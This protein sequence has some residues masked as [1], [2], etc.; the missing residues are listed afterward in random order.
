MRGPKAIVSK[1]K[2]ELESIAAGL[3]DRV[4]LGVS[5]PAAQHR[6]LIGRGG[7]T[8]NALQDKHSVQVQFPGSRSYSAVGEP[9]NASELTGV[10]AADLVKVSGGKNGCEAAIKEMLV[11]SKAFASNSAPKSRARVMSRLS[12]PLTRSRLPTVML[13]PPSRILSRC[14]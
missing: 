13:G 10:D 7:Q 3:R 6:A 11:R 5:I 2:A 4:V 12:L 8:L 9:S 14:P 1:L